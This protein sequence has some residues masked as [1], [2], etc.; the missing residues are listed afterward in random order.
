MHLMSKRK[1]KVMKK[2]EVMIQKVPE[3]K[4]KEDIIRSHDG[5]VGGG[6]GVP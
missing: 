4:F 1:K 2:R 5:W 6:G 3:L